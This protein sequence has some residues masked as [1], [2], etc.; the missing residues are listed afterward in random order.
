MAR[1][2]HATKKRTV[3]RRTSRKRGVKSPLRRYR[4][5]K[6]TTKVGRLWKY[7]KRHTKGEKGRC[8][9]LIYQ[10]PTYG[11]GSIRSLYGITL[12]PKMPY[13]VLTHYRMNLFVAQIGSANTQNP[14]FTYSS[15]NASVLT[16]ISQGRLG[17]FTGLMLKPYPKKGTNVN[18][19]TGNEFFL[20]SLTFNIMIH[21]KFGL[22]ETFQGSTASPSYIRGGS[23]SFYLIIEPTGSPGISAF[24]P[25]SLYC[26]IFD[27]TENYN[28][29]SAVPGGNDT[30]G[31][32]FT[33]ALR[34]DYFFKKKN[35][36]LS[37]K[38]KIVRLL[39]YDWT[40]H[41]NAITKVKPGALADGTGETSHTHDFTSGTFSGN[42]IPYFYEEGTDYSK[43]HKVNVKIKKRIKLVEDTPN[44]NNTTPAETAISN[45][46]L[47]NH[48]SSYNFWF[49]GCTSFFMRAPSSSPVTIEWN[50]ESIFHDV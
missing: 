26:Q 49:I 43:C 2:R 27:N 20:D 21:K 1:K 4:K 35:M 47:A 34:R 9:S 30:N 24:T 31:D 44:I 5:K 10:N 23:M 18:E 29:Y 46:G 48:A 8:D 19:I 40:V 41:T 22:H 12:Q 45:V 17:Y 14:S 3:R 6:A 25:D 15:S 37:P 32:I 36:A 28:N 16:A 39:K 42:P 38:V 50:C 33:S 7:V 13:R 11:A